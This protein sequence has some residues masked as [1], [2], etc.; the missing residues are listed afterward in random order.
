MF[1]LDDLVQTKAGP[2]KPTGLAV[3]RE[4]R[5]EAR[6]AEQAE[7]RRLS[8]QIATKVR[9]RLVAQEFLRN[10]QDIRKAYSD[11]VGKPSAKQQASQFVKNNFEAFVDE[12]QQAM[13]HAE[14]DKEQVLALLWAQAR[15]SILDFFNDDGEVMTIAEMK[16]LPPLLRALIEDVRVVNEEVA[17]TDDD[18]KVVKGPNDLPYLVTRQRVHI[19]LVDKQEALRQLAQIMKWVGPNVVVNNNTINYADVQV[20]AD[21]RISRMKSLYEGV[22]KDGG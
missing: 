2:V 3:P 22:T 12:L 17:L 9:A 19:K 6:K 15:T 5:A 11:V 7:S 4:D 21:A 14:V 10:G 8:K 20:A 1:K 16:K 18:G 13:S